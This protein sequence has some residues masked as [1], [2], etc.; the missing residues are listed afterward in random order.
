MFATPSRPLESTLSTSNWEQEVVSAQRPQ[1]Q[2]LNQPLELLQE[3]DSESVELRT[4]P[5]SQPTLPEE[6][7]V[8]EVED[9]EFPFLSW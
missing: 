6:L 8:E 9:S 2:V 1:D 3:L 7:V 5:Q 4:L